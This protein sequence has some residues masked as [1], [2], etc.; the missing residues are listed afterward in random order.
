MAEFDVL[1][2]VKELDNNLKLQWCLSDS[3]DK[4]KDVVTEYWDVFC[5]D[6]FRR[7]IWGFSFQIDTINHSPTRQKPSRYDPHES[8]V[9]RKLVEI[10]YENGVVE[11]DNRPWVSLVVLSKKP[12]K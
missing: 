1:T 11:E 4:V 10:M 2:N 7:T 12:Y 9:M 6:G 3:Q 8:E 5:E